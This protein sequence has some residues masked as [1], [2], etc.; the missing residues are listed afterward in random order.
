MSFTTQ[1]SRT[2]RRMTDEEEAFA[3]ALDKLPQQSTDPKFDTTSPS[4]GAKFKQPSPDDQASHRLCS[5]LGNR[6][7]FNLRYCS[8]LKVFF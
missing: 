6:V 7:E 5:N 1:W 3:D 4:L 2:P 8:K